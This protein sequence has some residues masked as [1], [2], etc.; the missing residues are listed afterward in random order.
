MTSAKVN[1]LRAVQ[2]DDSSKTISPWRGVFAYHE[3]KPA[4]AADAEFQHA[5]QVAPRDGNVYGYYAIFLSLHGQFNHAEEVLL[6][7]NRVESSIP[8]SPRGLV[9]A[10]L[11]QASLGSN[12]R[13]SKLNTDFATRFCCRTHVPGESARAIGQLR[14]SLGHCPTD[15]AARSVTRFRGLFGDGPQ[16][17][18][19]PRRRGADGFGK[20]QRLRLM[21]VE[22]C[23]VWEA[24]VL[25]GLGE[26]MPPSKSCEWPW[27]IPAR[28]AF[29]QNRSTSG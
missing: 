12:A 4:K 22:A 23:S 25:L 17:E 1:A 7:G 18:I 13:A 8:Q 19:G 3:S 5:L 16:P 21:S 14:R 9:L 10:L 28:S 29:Y 2:L 6:Q 11:L 24:Q 20:A 27:R 26:S 15:G